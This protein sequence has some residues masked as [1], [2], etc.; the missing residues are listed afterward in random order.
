MKNFLILIV[1]LVIAFCVIALAIWGEYKLIYPLIG[2]EYIEWLIIIMILTFFGLCWLNGIVL[3][4]L[5]PNMGMV[6]N[7]NYKGDKP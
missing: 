7:P 4:K 2:E 3:K 5:F 1:D 6:K